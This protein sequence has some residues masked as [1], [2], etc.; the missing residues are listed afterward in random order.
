M[1]CQQIEECAYRQTHVWDSAAVHS[2]LEFLRSHLGHSACKFHLS[3][4]SLIKGIKLIPSVCLVKS[5]SLQRN[6]TLR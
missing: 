5:S 4:I 1:K 3:I 2:A 6:V